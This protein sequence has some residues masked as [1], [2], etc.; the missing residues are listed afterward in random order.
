MSVK[1]CSSKEDTDKWMDE[2]GGSW[3]C[4]CTRSLSNFQIMSITVITLA[5]TARKFFAEGLL[6]EFV[7]QKI[8]WQRSVD[9]Q[10]LFPLKICGSTTSC[11]NIYHKILTRHLSS[12]TKTR[13]TFYEDFMQRRSGTQG[14]CQS[15]N[16]SD[17]SCTCP[18]RIKDEEGPQ[19]LIADPQRVEDSKIT[20]VLERSCNSCNKSSQKHNQTHTRYTYIKSGIVKSLRTS[21]LEVTSITM[22]RFLVGNSSNM[23]AGIRTFASTSA[24]A[25][26]TSLTS[27]IPIIYTDGACS[28]NGST[29][30]EVS[31]SGSFGVFWSGSEEKSAFGA[32]QGTATNN[33]AELTAA[34]EAVKQGISRGHKEIIIRTDSNY[35][36]NSMNTWIHEWKKN[37]WK[38]KRN[39]PL[40]NLDLMQELDALREQIKVNFQHVSGHNGVYGNE[41]AH[42]LAALGLP[43]L[44]DE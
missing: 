43:N 9:S 37:D 13:A 26:R 32:L 4:D 40:K 11:T 8:L 23:M 28:R 14:A 18:Q 44:K 17:I 2:N 38:R 15:S 30:V 1:E 33:R 21:E 36:V 3:I 41:K 7:T 25:S 19:P 39:K 42:K 34:L 22:K 29:D 20:V 24:V 27:S 31:S 16:I 12:F 5:E 10:I 6:C 35:V